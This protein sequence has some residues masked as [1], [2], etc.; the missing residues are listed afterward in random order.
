VNIHGCDSVVTLNLTISN[1]T[2]VGT[3]VVT[4][5]QSHQWIDGITYTSS[6]SSPTHILAGSNGC[7]STVSLNL[8][9]INVNISVVQNGTTLTAQASSA[10]FFWIDCST[11]AIVPGQMSSVFT[12]TTNGIYAVIVTQNG[13]SD[14][15]SCYTVSGIDLDENEMGLKLKVVPNPNHGDFKLIRSD[16]SNDSKLVIYSSDAKVIYQGNWSAGKDE[17]RMNLDLS[18]GIYHAALTDRNQTLFFKIEIF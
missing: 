17:K 1:Q 15:S 13:C 5:C 10:T 3:D 8:T 12:P 11:M 4:A 6:T 18:P 16:A 9:I 2:T 14:T 7:D